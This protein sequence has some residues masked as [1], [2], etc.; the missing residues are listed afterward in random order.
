M[1]CLVALICLLLIACGG[2]PAT[3]TPTDLHVPYGQGSSGV[4]HLS[5]GEE[6]ITFNGGS[7]PVDTGPAVGVSVRITNTGKIDVPVG[8][9]RVR[10]SDGTETE[11]ETDA[12]GPAG[13]GPKPQTST[14]SAGA[15]AILGGLYDR[16]KGL[17][18]KWFR[19]AVNGVAIY[20]DVG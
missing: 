4:L 10:W 5:G 14:L 1:R 18:L 9:L 12:L 19:Y 6:T 15:T 13:Q 8:V 11:R 16:P 3:I 20:F 7:D 17:T 2:T